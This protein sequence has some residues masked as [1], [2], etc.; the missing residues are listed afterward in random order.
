MDGKN[1]NV[2]GNTINDVAIAWNIL[3]YAMIIT[4]PC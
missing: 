4:V 1:A 3:I 2:Q